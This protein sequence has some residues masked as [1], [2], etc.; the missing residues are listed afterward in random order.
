MSPEESAKIIELLQEIQVALQTSQ[1]SKDRI[2]LYLIPNM[3]IIFGTSL[4]FFLFRW[5][6]QQRMAL[7]QAG[8]YKPWSFDLRAYSFLLGLLLTFIGIV[9]TIVFVAVLGVTL[10]LLGGLLPFAIGLGLLTY[11]KLTKP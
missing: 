11:Y 2:F 7:I 4:L 6:H 3:G 8:L 5:W 1:D 9:I 10:A